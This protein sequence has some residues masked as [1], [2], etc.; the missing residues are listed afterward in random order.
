MVGAWEVKE[1]GEGDGCR[2]Y[3]SSDGAN[4]QAEEGT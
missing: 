1:H 3:N 2:T 4:T